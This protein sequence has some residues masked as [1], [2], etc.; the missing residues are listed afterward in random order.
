[1]ELRRLPGRV[2]SPQALTI[3]AAASSI[4]FQLAVE[5]PRERNSMRLQIER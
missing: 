2:P 1:M 3:G 5:S 4:R